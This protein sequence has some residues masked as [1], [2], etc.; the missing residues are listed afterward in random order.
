MECILFNGLFSL[1]CS[2][3]IFSH[4]GCVGLHCILA[5]GLTDVG[6]GLVQ[7]AMGTPNREI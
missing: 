3:R 2:F 1:I 7:G 4:M 6:V 5:S